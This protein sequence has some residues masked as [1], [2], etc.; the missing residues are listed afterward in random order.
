LLGCLQKNEVYSPTHPSQYGVSYAL[1]VY[2]NQFKP[3]RP[4]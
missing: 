4:C 2:D 1:E 3:A